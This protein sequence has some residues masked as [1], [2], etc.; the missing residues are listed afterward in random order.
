MMAFRSH[1]FRRNITELM[2]SHCIYSLT[3]LHCPISNVNFDHLLRWV[4]QASP[5]WNYFALAIIVKYLMCVV[6]LCKY[7]IPHQTFSLFIHSFQFTVIAFFILRGPNVTIFIY[8]DAQIVP[9]LV[10]G[11]PFEMI[12][13]YFWH[14]PTCFEHFLYFL[15]K[16]INKF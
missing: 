12:S 14:A 2:C 3:Q 6:G 15:A 1:I 5:L 4:Y 10:C 9:N 8:S 16:K 7:T 11:S 13:M